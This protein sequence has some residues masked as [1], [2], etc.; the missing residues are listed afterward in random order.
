M[1]DIIPSASGGEQRPTPDT[2]DQLTVD[3]PRVAPFRAMFLEALETLLRD[4]PRGFS[5]A[6]IGWLAWQSLPES[7]HDEAME[8]FFYREWLELENKDKAMARFEREQST[9]TKLSAVLDDYETCL[10]LDTEVTPDL[11]AAMATLARTLLGGAR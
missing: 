11:V 5:A 1:P 10:V 3:L 6:D 8:R 4:R 9:R 7:L 2:F